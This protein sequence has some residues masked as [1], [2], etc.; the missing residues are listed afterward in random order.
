MT[1]GP[2]HREVSGAGEAGSVLRGEFRAV[3]VRGQ[4]PGREHHHA[5][6]GERADDLVRPHHRRTV[7]DRGDAVIARQARILADMA[8]ATTKEPAAAGAGGADVSRRT[9]LRSTSA[10]ITV[11]ARSSGRTQAPPGPA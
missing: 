4:V 5:R 9:V 10:R 2:A 1:K 11:A 6:G 7:G 8:P 3:G